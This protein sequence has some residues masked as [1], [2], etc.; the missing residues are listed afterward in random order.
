MT[1]ATVAGK[2]AVAVRLVA[3][4]TGP[5]FAECELESDAE[6]SG[7]VTLQING[8]S[9]IGTVDESNN[10]VFEGS[11]KLRI[12]AGGNGWWRTVNPK[13]YH[14]DAQV[15]ART[16]VEDAARAVG[17]TLGNFVPAAERI[18]NDY[19]RDR[20]PASQV[21]EDVIGDVPWWVDYD[22][23]THVGSRPPLT[24]ASEAYQVLAYDPADRRAIL[25]VSDVLAIQIGTVI[26]KSLGG[27][28]T[29]RE[30]EIV[31][32]AEDLRVTAW[33]G[34]S[35]SSAGHLADLMRAIVQ[36]TTD[37]ALYGKYRYRVVRMSVDR[38]ECQ[39]VRK[40]AGLPDVLP[41]SMWP[42]VAGAHAEL[43]PGAEVLVEFIEGDRTMPIITHFAGKDGK[44][45]A[46][47]TLTLGGADGP[48]C[49]RKGDA[50]EVLLPPAV[51]SGTIGGV[52]ATGVLTFTLNKTLG[53]ITAG[54]GKVKVAT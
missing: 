7:Q 41:V 50:V 30:L 21:L 40:A 10:G 15:K 52:P 14:N 49:A 51:F 33:C 16:V 4:H 37:A 17:E 35:A 45:H 6:L 11:R 36:R 27:P 19:V 9:F 25:G 38:V 42:G 24:V 54:S 8:A 23:V 2:R 18:G 22:G 20:G 26:S 53:S 47:V 31:V 43:T 3:G 29:V 39:A 1:F 12:L 5:W 34:G 32:D 28:Q 48:E 46:P 13:H 44:G